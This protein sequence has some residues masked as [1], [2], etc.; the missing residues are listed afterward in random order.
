MFLRCTVAVHRRPLTRFLL[1]CRYRAWQ[2]MV[3]MYNRQKY[4]VNG[5][6]NR[7]RNLALSKAWEQ[8]QVLNPN[9]AS[10]CFTR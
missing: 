2:H 8:W 3:Q 4:L 9:T 1:L 5:C 7:M 6:L 10:T